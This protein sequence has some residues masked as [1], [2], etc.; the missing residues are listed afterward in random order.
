MDKNTQTYKVELEF[1][2]DRATLIKGG[3]YDVLYKCSSSNS[4]RIA[5]AKWNGEQFVY[6]NTQR[7]VRKKAE[8]SFEKKVRQDQIMGWMR[9]E[10]WSGE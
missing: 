2:S 10:L 8:P 4:S 3:I 7:F 9:H 6:F 1:T 5:P